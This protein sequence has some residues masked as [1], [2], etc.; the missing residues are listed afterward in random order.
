M[1]NDSGRMHPAVPS[2]DVGGTKHAGGVVDT[3]AYRDWPVRELLEKTTALPVTVDNDANVAALA[4]SR[5]GER[6]YHDRC[7]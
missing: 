7:C 4:E 5:P 6:P 1:P 3:N 2:A